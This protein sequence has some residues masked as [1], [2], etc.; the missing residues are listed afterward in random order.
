M[1]MAGGSNAV[2]AQ[3]RDGQ[4]GCSQW[5]LQQDLQWD[6]AGSKGGSP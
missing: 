1:K 5:D 6:V 2:G 4:A 3:P